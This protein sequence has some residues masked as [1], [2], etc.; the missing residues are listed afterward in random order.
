MC[1]A[2]GSQLSGGQKQRSQYTDDA[3]T[4]EK[5]FRLVAIARAL[6]RSPKILLV[7]E[8]TSALDKKSEQLVQAALDTARTDRTRQSERTSISQS[9]VS[10]SL[11]LHRA[12]SRA[13]MKN[14]FN[15]MELIRNWLRHRKD[16]HEDL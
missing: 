10:F 12:T 16:P 4:K 3:R 8:V 5:V 7:D 11:C 9:S 13:Q 2:K 1:G 14:K 6:I 15:S